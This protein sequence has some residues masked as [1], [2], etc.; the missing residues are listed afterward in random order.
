M[1]IVAVHAEDGTVTV[2]GRD[3]DGNAASHACGADQLLFVDLRAVA[4]SEGAGDAR[5]FL[6][7]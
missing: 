7:R 4:A 6:P 3:E 5:V 2:V 1:P